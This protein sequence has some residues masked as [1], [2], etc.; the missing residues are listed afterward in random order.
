MFLSLPL[1][2]GVLAQAPVSDTPLAPAPA[3][4]QELPAG[5]C[6]PPCEEVEEE[7]K[8]SPWTGSAALSFMLLAGNS[9][10]LALTANGLAEYRTDAW[11]VMLKGEGVLDL[12]ATPGGDGDE[13]VI[14]EAAALTARGEKRFTPLLGVYALVG[15]KTDHLSSVERRLDGEVGA[16]LTLI[17]RDTRFKEEL[18]LRLDL[19]VHYSNEARF[20]YFEDEHDLPNVDLLAP[21]VRVTLYCPINER[22][23]L[24]QYA[25]F[26][27]NILGDTRFLVES[28]TKLSAFITN[29]LALNMNLGVDVDTAP[30]EGKKVA[31]LALTV[32]AEFEF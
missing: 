1:L 5:Y 4:S 21:G 11:D 19:G 25:E 16:G 29:R 13:E 10:A 3:E 32:G 28:T 17:E 18:F 9:R 30:A 7:K 20:Q 12:A 14:A 2:L 8:P 22:L 27:P 26:F 23:K 6:K 24:T 15:A 31:D